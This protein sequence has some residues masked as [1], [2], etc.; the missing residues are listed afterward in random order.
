MVDSNKARFGV[1]NI[2]FLISCKF[3]Q[4]FDSVG[5][6]SHTHW[7]FEKFDSIGVPV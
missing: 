6:S 4:V 5:Q 1:K 2:E 7:T 3:Q